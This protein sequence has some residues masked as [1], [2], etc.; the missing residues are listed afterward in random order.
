MELDD[1]TDLGMLGVPVVP[2]AK[3]QRYIVLLSLLNILVF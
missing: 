1:I 3:M 2:R